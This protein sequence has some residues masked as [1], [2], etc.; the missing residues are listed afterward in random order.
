V[1]TLELDLKQAL[2]GWKR[3]VSTI[4]GKNINIERAGP[5]QPGSQ[6]A[7]PNLGMPTKEPGKRGDFIV[8]YSVKFPASLTPQQ[9]AAFEEVL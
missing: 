3:T 6:D 9:R 2:T 7:Y 8:R 5:T 4:D 1:L